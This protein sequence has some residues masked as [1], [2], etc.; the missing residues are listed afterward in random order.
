[1]RRRGL[2]LIETLVALGLI[3]V[4]AIVSLPML[5]SANS[6]A[7]SSACR[8]NLLTLGQ[9]LEQS[10]DAEGRLPAMMNRDDLSLAVPTIDRVL[11]LDAMQR[12]GLRCPSDDAEHASRSGTSYQWFSSWDSHGGPDFA[13]DS[14]P[15]TPL[16]ADKAPFHTDQ[17]HPY[18]A[19]FSNPPGATQSTSNRL[20]DRY[21]AGPYAMP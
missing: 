7:R 15:L 1:M 18:N 14:E 6:E 5:S 21:R 2:N 4:L 3:A 16:L 20:T 12:A 11:P 8:G 10:R 17:L 9:A 19:L 13:T